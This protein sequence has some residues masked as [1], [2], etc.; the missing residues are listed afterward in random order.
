MC[1]LCTA[2]IGNWS[3][4]SSLFCCFYIHIVAGFENLATI[5]PM[6]KNTI[7]EKHNREGKKHAHTNIEFLRRVYIRIICLSFCHCGHA[8]LGTSDIKYIW[9]NLFYIFTR[10]AF[11]LFSV[12][13]KCVCVCMH[14]YKRT[15]IRSRMHRHECVPKFNALR[16]MYECHVRPLHTAT[17]LDI[18]TE[19][20]L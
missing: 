19:I 12:G 20:R 5:I 13:I 8:K 15:I 18:W 6:R 9:F 3:S 4:K 17:P 1:T 7:Q 10:I 11:L 14:K 2:N 16:L